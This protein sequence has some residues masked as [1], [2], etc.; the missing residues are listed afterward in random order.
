MIRYPIN[1]FRFASTLATTKL[2]YD[3][4]VW[5]DID[6]LFLDFGD[7]ESGSFVVTLSIPSTWNDILSEV[8]TGFQVVLRTGSGSVQTLASGS[9]TSPAAYQV[10]AFSLTCYAEVSANQGISQIF[11]Q[12]LVPTGGGTAHIDGVS[13]LSA[14]GSLAPSKKPFTDLTHWENPELFSRG[15]RLSSFS[16]VLFLSGYGPTE[17]GGTPGHQTNKIAY[18]ND[19]VKQMQWIVD[20]LDDFF[21]TIQYADGTDYYSKYDIVYFDLVVDNSISDDDQQGVLEVLIKWFG[22]EGKNIS[23][24]PKPSTGILKKVAGLAVSGIMV[25]IEFILAH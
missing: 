9:H 13:S 12:W 10:S 11:A 4:P 17:P 18:P 23:V 15:L 24:Y 7:E 5:Q 8:G 19:A 1:E 25:E 20:H 16:E 21:A 3:Q 14:V 2:Q 22:P 6:G